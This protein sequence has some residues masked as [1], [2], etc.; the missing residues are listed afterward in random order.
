MSINP[1]DG[2]AHPFTE[3]FGDH[4]TFQQH[5]GMTIS[6]VFAAISLHALLT[7]HHGSYADNGEGCSCPEYAVS[8][9][10]HRQSLAELAYAMSDA[11]LNERTNRYLA[12]IDDEA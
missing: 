4:T 11:M 7:R 8:Q 3:I 12:E 1:A 5:P 9:P 2:Y 10:V 6:D